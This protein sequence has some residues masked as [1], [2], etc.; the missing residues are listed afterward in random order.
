MLSFPIFYGF[1]AK[2]LSFNEYSLI[3]KLAD[4]NTKK[5]NGND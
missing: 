1:F 5:V 2:K 3:C 4:L